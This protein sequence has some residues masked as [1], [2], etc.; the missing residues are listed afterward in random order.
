MLTIS[1]TD[2]EQGYEVA[3]LGESS[4][5]LKVAKLRGSRSLSEV[6]LVVGIRPEELSKIESGK[7]KQIRW[8]T[9]LG[10]MR[11][12]DCEL[13]DILEKCEKKLQEFPERDR[14]LAAVR[15]NPKKQAVRRLTPY[16]ENSPGVEAAALRALTA[17]LPAR[18]I[19]RVAPEVIRGSA[20]KA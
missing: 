8:V 4:L 18:E 2:K 13:G 3:C 20:E 10:L 12:Y 16:D 11:A 17:A 19:R 1:P 14:F 6:A 15:A 7:T 5:V 9:L